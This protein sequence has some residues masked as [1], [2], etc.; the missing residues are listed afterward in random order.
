MRREWVREAG[1]RLR[2]RPPGKKGLQEIE[3]G[4]PGT[5]VPQVSEMT[6]ESKEEDFVVPDGCKRAESSAA[7]AVT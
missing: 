6:S 7:V 3:Q 4:T 1:S 2:C 5:W